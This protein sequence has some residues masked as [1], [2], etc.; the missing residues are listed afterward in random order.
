MAHLCRVIVTS[1]DELVTYLSIYF[2]VNKKNYKFE[3]T[4][5]LNFKI[6]L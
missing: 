1:H 5:R 2:S 4:E 6:K 3:E